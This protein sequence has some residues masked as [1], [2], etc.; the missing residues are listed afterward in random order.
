MH[1]TFQRSNKDP[2]F[3]FTL[4]DFLHSNQK[5]KDKAKLYISSRQWNNNRLLLFQSISDMHNPNNRKSFLQ[6]RIKIF[7]IRMNQ[8]IKNNHCTE[9]P[10]SVCCYVTLTGCLQSNIRN[11]TNQSSRLSNVRYLPNKQ[12]LHAGLFCPLPLPILT[13]QPLPRNRLSTRPSHQSV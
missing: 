10:E 9:G 2:T 12:W 1:I 7:K 13:R 11:R 8:G 4:Q 6:G 5:L 3:K